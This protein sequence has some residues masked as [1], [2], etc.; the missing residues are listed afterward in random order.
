MS[1]AS[2]IG[3]G[4]LAVLAAAGA[5]SSCTV[6]FSPAASSLAT[7]WK[8]TGQLVTYYV[9]ASGND[10]A[11]GTSPATAWRSLGKVSATHL[12]PGASVLL[13]GGQQF[14]GTLRLGPRDGGDP[15]RPVV[16]GSYGGQPASIH[17]RA[18]SGVSV[19]DTAGVTIENIH[20]TG[21]PGPA[22]GNGLDI[23]SDLPAGRRLSGIAVSGVDASGFLAGIS[24]GAK[25]AAAGF[26][27]VRVSASRLH[28]N[29]DVG[30]I[31]YGPAFT[32]AAPSYA[33]QDIS[34]SGVIA[35]GNLG[36]AGNKANDTG[37][38]IVLGSVAHGKVTM[39]VAT[40][41]G[42]QGA[43]VLGPAGIWTYDST[44]IVIEHSLAYF[45]MTKNEV[46]GNGFGL[47]QNTTDSVLQDNFS[48]GNGG[49]G[50][51]VYS[52]LN[53]HGEQGNIVRDNISSYDERDGSSYY[54]G[55]TVIGWVSDLALYQNTVV[56][57]PQGPVSPP[58]LRLSAGL[59]GVTI[60]NNIFATSSG[61]VVATVNPLKAS[62]ADLQGNDYR[63]VSGP[64]QVRWG[65]ASYRSLSQWQAAAGQEMVASHP[66]GLT[67]EPQFAGQVFNL[68]ATSLAGV[69]AAARGFRLAAGSPA[70]GAGL[71]L[72]ALGGAPA[73]VNFLGNPQSPRHPDI[74]AL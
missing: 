68:S 39:S 61:P 19:H 59:S 8:S 14:T 58:A 18:G 46:D 2:R 41:N 44:G 5:L 64:W 51:L 73:P 12:P 63:C 22:D 28:G 60:R 50:Y 10:A 48:Y 29:T 38:G 27:H 16:I 67:A 9:S 56:M 36:D 62:Q 53:D 7:G 11:A 70:I 45:N 69:A 47:D 17:A 72:A 24:I 57:E 55:I 71:D 43:A 13:H 25:S 52:S 33:H 6:V 74:G 21:T 23:Y 34:V 40:G 54:G 65:S 35:S 31:S 20:L 42:G 30:L 32:P 1:R 26:S 15:A 4:L 3:P 49:T 66:A 37:N